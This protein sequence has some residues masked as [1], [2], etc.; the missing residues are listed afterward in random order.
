MRNALARVSKSQ[1][2]AAQ[3]V[4]HKGETMKQTVEDFIAGIRAA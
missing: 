1:K 3:S 4:S 2:E